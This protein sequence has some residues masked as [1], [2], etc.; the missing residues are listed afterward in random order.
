MLDFL[1]SD[2]LQLTFFLITHGAIT[3]PIF[4][5][6]MCVYFSKRKAPWVMSIWLPTVLFSSVYLLG[7]CVLF[8]EN[9]NA[10]GGNAWGL[11]M[12]L[13]LGSLIYVPLGFAL[14]SML[15]RRPPLSAW[16][17]PYIF[18]GLGSVAGVCLMLRIAYTI[19]HVQV[20]FLVTNPDGTPISHAGFH[21]YKRTVFTNSDGTLRLRTSEQG[22]LYGTFV[23]AGYQDHL[24]STTFMGMNRS[25]I[26]VR[27]SLVSKNGD[28][29]IPVPISAPIRIVMQPR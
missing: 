20:T 2:F 27:H 10:S 16:K 11:G 22:D 17:P 13:L 7:F 1:P 6:V 25:E 26:I 14:I 28:P 29:E 4:I 9:R 24:I 18:F 23:M 19:V 3:L 15:K 12:I 21:M 8:F 5:V